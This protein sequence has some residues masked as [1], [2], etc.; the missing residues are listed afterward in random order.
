[1]AL[2]LVVVPV[3]ARAQQSAGQDQ[4]TA[5]TPAVKVVSIPRASRKPALSDFLTGHAPDLLVLSDFRQR[6]PGDGSPASQRTAA[7]LSYDSANLYVVFVCSDAPGRVRAHM[8]RREDIFDDDRVAVY[9][10]SFHDH[11]RAYL[12][13]ANPLGIQADALVTDG[14]RT[15][16]YT[17]DTYWHSEGRLTPE[18]YIVIMTIPFK[19]LRFSASEAPRWGFALGRTIMRNGETSF[20]PHLSL[21]QPA[22]VGQ[23]A[24]LRGLEE[25]APGRN[26]QLVPYT[27]GV[28]A[29][30]ANY[31]F[32]G[33]S[34]QGE[35]RGG[36]DAKFVIRSALTLDL[37]VNPDFSQVESD[38]PQV[39]I[40]RRFETY[41]PEKRPFF[42]EDAGYFATPINLF[43][44]RKIVDPAFG[45]RLTGRVGQWN[46]G[47]LAIDD[48]AAG[49]ALS[50]GD[51]MF[52]HHARIGAARAQ[53]DFGN[54]SYF[55]VMLTS[56]SFGAR[57]NEVASFD[58]RLRLS[59]TWFFTGQLVRTLTDSPVTG[60]FPRPRLN[61]KGYS[62]QLSHSDRHLSYTV[63]YLDLSPE[64][65][66]EIG[67]VPR[68][69]VRQAQNY[70]GYFWRPENSRILAYGLAATVTTNWDRR[71]Q[72]QDA[73]SY[74][75]FQMDFTGRTGLTVTRYDAMERYLSRSFEFAN[76]GVSFYA[77]WVK[78]L[79]MSGSYAQGGSVNYYPAEG[80]SPYL[81]ASR[82][83][84]FN[85]KLRPRPRVRIEQMYYYSRLAA[86]WQTG[87]TVGAG[88]AFNNHLSRT[89]VHYQF[90]RALSLRGILDF[91]GLLANTAL[92]GGDSTKRLT[93]DLLLTYLLNP[94]TALYVGV[95]SNYEN[96]R[97]NASDSALFRSGAPSYLT[98][99]QV[100]VKLT[101][102]LRF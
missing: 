26:I 30:I 44:T 10:D 13:S 97:A 87:W 100:F 57:S 11:K 31:G 40:N 18:G 1:V 72:L 29:R 14:A 5:T 66:S 12:F 52:G 101:Y 17:F 59:P 81:G 28:G 89:V 78:W 68:V 41:F 71:G 76:T 91:N 8:S 49:H 45:A 50:A 37:T 64:F 56:R 83:A 19:S 94:G 20:V 39:T 92:F 95:N 3:A 16:D 21:R 43:F 15:P 99:R 93:G 63:S 80:L 23:F 102:R 48:R 90:N 24:E 98:G 75:Q 82:N 61:G 51:P 96:F 62:A 36:M 88:V 70:L 2:L 22:F 47:A 79:Y 67:F 7:Y 74:V 42:I 6:E 32:S 54:Q 58:T 38:D 25:V 55:G 85:L 53:R 33:Y 77:N 46:V 34:G 73:N 69:D 35:F 86:R 65:R 9:L 84:S 4:L 60:A 27:T